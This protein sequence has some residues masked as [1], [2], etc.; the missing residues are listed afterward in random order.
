MA[1]VTV[2]GAP[3]SG[4][5]VGARGPRL[6]L[7]VAGAG[8]AAS[9]FVLAGIGPRTPI[10][11]L[12]VGYLCF[13]IGFGVL[14]APITNAAVSGMPRDRRR[15]SRRRWPRRAARSGFRWAWR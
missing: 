14:N 15:A 2:V 1:A 7:L 8:I 4:R 13:G 9:G 12:V 3:L 6:P 10:S 5:V 11:L